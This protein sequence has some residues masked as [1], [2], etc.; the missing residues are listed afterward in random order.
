M[1]LSL[2]V[3]KSRCGKMFNR[4]A[5][6]Y[7]VLNHIFSF[8]LD[9]L[10]RRRMLT[11]LPGGNGLTILDLATGTAAVPLM[12]ARSRKDVRRII[13]LD[14]AR[15]MLAVGRDKIQRARLTERIVLQA[16]DARNIPI[17]DHEFDVVTMAFG[18]RNVPE[19]EKV[20][21]EMLRV[22]KKDGR[23]LILEF[24]LPLRPWIRKIAVFYI[25]KIIPV[26]GRW[27]YPEEMAYH[28][29]GSSIVDFPSGSSF[30]SWLREAGFN[31][32]RMHPMFFGMATVYE[33]RKSNVPVQ[34]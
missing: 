26:I 34:Q 20:L 28:Y 33:G 19:P 4:I 30:A 14:F 12:I 11:F 2:S 6:H 17:G 21:K 22:L 1:T 13:G 32:V 25:Q 16:A 24:S 27:V 18:I 10:W 9:I 5:G 23:A 29:L 3:E 7:D 15:D 8:G 31:Q